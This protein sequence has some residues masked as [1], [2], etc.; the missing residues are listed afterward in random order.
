VVWDGGLTVSGNQNVGVREINFFNPDK[1][2]RRERESVAWTSVTTGNFCAV[3]LTLADAEAGEI[4]VETKVGRLQCAIRDIGPEPLEIDCGKLDRKLSAWRLADEG[5]VY[6]I[7]VSR[8]FD[9]SERERRLLV[10]LT[11]E[12]GH[13]AW[14]SPLYLIPEGACPRSPSSPPPPAGP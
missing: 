3:E 9:V 13:R 6:S 2:A 11:L 14:S 12:D 5:T 8:E 4:S 1:P 10:A 7:D